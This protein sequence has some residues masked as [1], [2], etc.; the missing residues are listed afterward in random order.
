MGNQAGRYRNE[1]KFTALDHVQIIGELLA[2]G[3]V[4]IHHE[5]LNNSIYFDTPNLRG[6][7]EN[8]NGDMS[9]VKHRI[10]FYGSIGNK[11]VSFEKKIKTGRVNKKIVFKRQLGSDYWNEA[12]SPDEPT[13]LALIH[14]R[15]RRRYFWDPV[16][17]IRCTV[18]WNLESRLKHNDFWLQHKK[19]VIEFKS[20]ISNNDFKVPF[21]L[22][23]NTRFSKYA[24]CLSEHMLSAEAY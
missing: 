5:R 12:F 15:Y 1:L 9:R 20:E 10:R 18:D 16:K 22:A 6:Y 17:E 24:F 14:L 7:Y 13:L 8:L 3:Y 21:Q 4:E 19:V 11:K 23:L 2:L